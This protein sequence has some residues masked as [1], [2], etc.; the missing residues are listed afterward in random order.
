VRRWDFWF[1]FALHPLRPFLHIDVL[2]IHLTNLIVDPEWGRGPAIVKI[3]TSLTA[4]LTSFQQQFLLPQIYFSVCKAE[5]KGWVL[6]CQ[7]IVHV[8]CSIMTTDHNNIQL[9]LDWTEVVLNQYQSKFVC[10]TD[11][12]HVSHVDKGSKQEGEWS[13]PSLSISIRSVIFWTAMWRAAERRFCSWQMKVTGECDLFD[14]FETGG[15]F[16]LFLAHSITVIIQDG[17]NKGVKRVSR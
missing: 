2:S 8:S 4:M 17:R 1:L 11:I 7:Q 9:V 10:S 16:R 12:R 14:I 15:R 3:I 6:K 13:I 5:R